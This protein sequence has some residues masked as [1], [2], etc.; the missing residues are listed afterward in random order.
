AR[1]LKTGT[2]EWTLVF[3]TVVTFGAVSFEPS[4]SGTV[5]TRPAQTFDQDYGIG[6]TNFPVLFG[7]RI[8]VVQSGDYGITY[9]LSEVLLGDESFSLSVDAASVSGLL[10]S[11]ENFCALKIDGSRLL[12]L[13]EGYPNYSFRQIAVFERCTPGSLEAVM[14]DIL[15][16]AGYDDGDFDVSALSDTTLRGYVLQEPMSARG[17]IEPL[18]TYAPF[19]LIETEGQL[20][21]VLRGGDAVAAFGQEDLRAAAEDK[22][23]PAA[24]T[25]QRAEELDLPLEVD[26][27][28]VDPARNFEVNCQRARRLASSA[29]KIQKIALP[30]VCAAQTAK[31]I[32]QTRLFTTWAERELVKLSAP[33]AWLALDPADVFSL[34]DGVL[35]RIASVVQSGGVLRIEGFY[36]YAPGLASSSLADGGAGLANDAAEA[37]SSVLYLMDLPLLQSADD[38]AGFYASVTGLPGWKSAALMRSADGADY[39]AVAA[40]QAA[41][42]AGIAASAL[43]EGSA[44]YMDNASSVDVQVTQ[45]SLASCSFL[46]LSN[47][48]NAALLGDEIVQFQTATLT[49]PGLYTLSNLLRGRRG[50]ENAIFGHAAGERFVLLKAGATVFVPAVLSDRDKSY[51][52]RALS[53]NQSLGDAQDYSFAC[54]LR[55]LRPFAPANLSGVRSLGTGGDL[56]LSWTRRAR[57]DAEWV[58]YIDVPLDE[59]EELY[60]AEI[61]DGEDVIR[62]FSGLGSPGLIYSADQQ[63]T[64]WSGGIPPAFTVNVYQVSPRYGRGDAATATV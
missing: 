51:F 11:Y 53:A 57:L 50:T 64:D 34:G 63:A 44:F 29:R 37:V 12:F 25:V 60:E 30:V 43:G 54:G 31:Q 17:A 15:S 39:A 58:D 52:F 5:I 4:A 23:Q 13:A 20:K 19:D 14:S 33:R 9:L 22:A 40:L 16:R 47:G 2:N 3:G 42:T 32:A 8:V 36:S 62:T 59:T 18:Q 6:T 61:M 48:A 41:A 55:T 46:D 35:L 26:I 21:A 1:F 56:T 27:E 38:Q 7:D 28:F 45:G 49:G 24:L 10:N